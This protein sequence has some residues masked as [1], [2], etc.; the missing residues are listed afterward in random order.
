[1]NYGE[2]ISTLAF[3]NFTVLPV[4]ILRDIQSPAILIAVLWLSPL[5]HLDALIDEGHTE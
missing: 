1:M 5:Y 4:A 3:D 2:S